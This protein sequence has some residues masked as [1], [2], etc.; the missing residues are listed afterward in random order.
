[1]GSKFES[2]RSA[3]RATAV[4]DLLVGG[5]REISSPTFF[6]SESKV[7]RSSDLR[8]IYFFR[9]LRPAPAFPKVTFGIKARLS[10]TASVDPYFIFPI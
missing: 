1:M 5:E 2:S 7:D 9:L 4:N 6:C 8:Y 10:F 3:Q